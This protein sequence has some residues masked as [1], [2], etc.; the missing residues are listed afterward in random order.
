[1]MPEHRL[2]PVAYHVLSADNLED[3][4]RVTTI[5]KQKLQWSMAVAREAGEVMVFWKERGRWWSLRLDAS[6]IYNDDLDDVIREAMRRA[7]G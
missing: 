5:A 4:S 3:I 1:M 6:Y 7:H 2:E